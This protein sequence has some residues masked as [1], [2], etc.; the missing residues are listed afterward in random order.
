MTIASIALAKPLGA[1]SFRLVR[2]APANGMKVANMTT[3]T[4]IMISI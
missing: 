3:A 2:R 4:T 1:F